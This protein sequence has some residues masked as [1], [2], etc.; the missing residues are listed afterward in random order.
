MDEKNMKPIVNYTIAA[1]RE[2]HSADQ[3]V[4]R[5]LRFTLAMMAA[6]AA[7]LSLVAVAMSR[8]CLRLHSTPNPEW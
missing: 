6:G 7:A 5:R 8:L 4:I 3:N 1:T 2:R